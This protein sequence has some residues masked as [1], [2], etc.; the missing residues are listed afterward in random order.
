MRSLSDSDLLHLWEGGLSRH[1]LD[2]ALLALGAAFPETPYERF[3]DWP[4]G[5]RNKAL[6]DLRCKCFGARIAGWTSCAA[7]G[8]N[9][10]FDLD[11]RALTIVG[12]NPD[13][14]SYANQQDE[15]IVVNQRSYRLPTSRDLAKVAQETDPRR[16]AIRIVENCRLAPAAPHAPIEHVANSLSV[17]SSELWSDEELDEIGEQMALADPLAETR[18]TLHCPKCE[19]DWEEA[20]DIIAFL[21]AEIEA[22]AR[23]LLWEIHSLASAYG[24]SETE[25][26]SLSELRR[27][28]YVEMVQS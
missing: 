24:W 1:P 2:R 16:A 18:L 3:A 21:W 14:R 22:H 23:R 4:L 8:E 12:M 9:L 5:R 19:N 6:V 28:R 26:L 10:E 27:A 25:I 17:P 15:S 20:L 7:C 13:E 11:G